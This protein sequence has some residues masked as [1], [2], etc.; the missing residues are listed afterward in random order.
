MMSG[1]L[2]DHDV[3]HTAMAGCAYGPA[4]RRGAGDPRICRRTRTP[5]TGA[6]RFG[7]GGYWLYQRD[8][9]IGQAFQKLPLPIPADT[10]EVGWM[11]AGHQYEFYVVPAEGIV[12]GGQS[13]VA[14]AFANPRTAAPPGNIVATP[15]P[16][17]IDLTWTPPTGPFTD[18]LSGYRLYYMDK[19]VTDGFL[20][21]VTIGAGATSY[22]LT[23]LVPGHRYN[24]AMSSINAAGDGFPNGTPEIVVG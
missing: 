13:A 11:Q 20:Q 14:S 9:T 17:Y 12:E 18:T 15:G 1:R 3:P 22:R 2:R 23:G 7:A 10:W 19:S 6:G 4:Q 5:P 24:L 16:N 8:A 21:A